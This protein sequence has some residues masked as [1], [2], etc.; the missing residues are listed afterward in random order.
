[1]QVRLEGA[2]PMECL[3]V[4]DIGVK[5]IGLRLPFPLA[6]G[7]EAVVVIHHPIL[8]EPLRLDARAAWCRMVPGD[9]SPHAGL[10]FAPT[11]DEQRLNLRRVQASEVSC[12]VL[13]GDRTAGFVMNQGEG[14]WALYDEH[15]VKV[16][17][18]RQEGGQFRVTFLGASPA[19][20]VSTL[21]ADTLPDALALA[22]ELEHPPF[23]VPPEG[24]HWVPIR[25]RPSPTAQPSPA[26]RP[27]VPRPPRIDASRREPGSSPPAEAS[28]EDGDRTATVDPQ[29]AKARPVAF[30]A[31][32]AGGFHVGFV[33]V[34]SVEDVWSVY[35]GEW[36]ELAILSPHRGGYKLVHMGSDPNDSLDFMLARSFLGGLQLA[37]D[38]KLQPELD[39]PLPEPPPEP[40][41]PDAPRPLSPEES[42]EE[43]LEADR[44]HHAIVD[45]QQGLVG[46]VAPSTKGPDRW[47]V[48]ST[49]R[50]R[51]ATIE[52]T[53]DRFRIVFAGQ[54]PGDSLEYMVA[55]NFRGALALTFDLESL[56]AL[57][58]PLDV[59]R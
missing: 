40:E 30:H 32:L 15:T 16:G 55:R 2:F 27:A 20:S 35:D 47:S 31:V 6:S 45:G 10:E 50:E 23:V 39:P 4:L 42:A 48:Y 9:P 25:S 14:C 22:L 44:P 43:V 54:E 59:P 57:D 33:A 51:V 56:P 18:L 21:D 24:G 58:P 26:T 36:N 49:L 28:P 46:Y 38:L 34:T 1:M 7:Q 52:R 13:D 8:T 19:E 3:E 53:A 37:F 11:S 29:T 41:A 5:G 12:R 17:T